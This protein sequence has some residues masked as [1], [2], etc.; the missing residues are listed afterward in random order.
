MITHNI[1]VTPTILYTAAI[2]SIINLATS[3]Q[4]SISPF[5]NVIVVPA[6]NM[7]Q[8]ITTIRHSENLYFCKTS[9]IEKTI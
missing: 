7:Q 1:Y 8:I 2:S 9:R 5:S 3:K 4:E 6:A